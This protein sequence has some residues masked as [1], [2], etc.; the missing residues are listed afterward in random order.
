MTARSSLL[1][2]LRVLVPL[3]LTALGPA[4]ARAGSHLWR[5]HEFYSSPDR[6][7]QFIVFN[8]LPD[9]PPLL[10]LGSRNA[11]AK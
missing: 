7:V 5:F 10:S 4:G 1:P 3:L 2:R 8:T 9:K 11:I 6:S